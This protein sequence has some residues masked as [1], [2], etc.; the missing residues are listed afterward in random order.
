MGSAYI[1]QIPLILTHVK[2]GAAR[3]LA[4]YTGG[5]GRW[6]RGTC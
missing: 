3:M 4:G 1:A 5:Q 6:I 2:C